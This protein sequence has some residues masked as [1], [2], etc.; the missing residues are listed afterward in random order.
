MDQAA[1]FERINEQRDFLTDLSG[2]LWETPELGLHEHESANLLRSELAVAGFAVESGVGGMPTAFVARYEG[3]DGPTIGILGEFDALPGL[4]QAVKAERDPVEPGG[5]GHGCGHNLLGVAGVGAA[6]ALKKTIAGG[7]L[8]GTVVYYG[9]PAEETLVG[10]VFMSRAGAFDDLDAALTWHPGRYASPIMAST[11]AMNSVQYEFSGTSAHAA[12]SPESGRSA[13]DAVQLLN[14]GAEYMREHVPEEARVHYSIVNGGDAPNVVP[15]SAT[16]WYFVRAPERETVESIQDWL[17]DIADGAATMTRTEC[18][19]RFLTGC[20]G[21]LPNETIGDLMYENMAM[22]ESIPYT[23]EDRE[24]AAELKETLAPETIE[25]QLAD[26]P[27][28]MLAEVDE[29]ALY[30]DPL[31]AYDG[32]TIRSGSTDVGDVSRIAP[33]GQFWDA[34]WPVG[35]NAHSWQA[36]AA[37]GSFAPKAMIHAAKVLAGTV[38]DL[39]SD[40]A[41]LAA[42]RDEFER[43]RDGDYESSLPDGLER[44]LELSE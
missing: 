20:H 14:T 43:T 44:P 29:H 31:P 41:A 15:E 30:T 24:F 10:K 42:A 12:A 34:T 28:E 32:G 6:I 26:L 38:A 39:L 9:C 37:N 23:D 4:S 21:V 18:E 7:D 11:L 27:P 35:T 8:S 40:P 13:L 2:E 16:V 25:G 17:D 1:M 33:L 3:G 5:P 19:R 22:L 36:V